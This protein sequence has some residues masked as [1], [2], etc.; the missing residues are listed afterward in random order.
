MDVSVLDQ[1]G[2]FAAGLTAHDFRVLDNGIEQPV[3]FFSPVESPAQIL[4]M[5]E[6]SPAVYLIRKEHISAAYALLDGLAPDDEVALAIYDATPHGV[7]GFTKDKAALLAALSQVQYTIG[8]DELNLYNSISTVLDWVGSSTGKKA[9][10]LLSTGLDSSPSPNWDALIKKLRG[11]DVV[12]F[13]VALGGWLRG[14]PSHKSSAKKKTS[15]GNGKQ[16]PESPPAGNSEIFAKA[17]AALLSLAS[18]TG[19]RAYC[20]ESADDFVPI[21]RQIAYELRNE[22]VLGIQPAQDGQFHSLRVEVIG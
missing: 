11:H 13:P 8:M 5:L 6:T 18:M 14:G 3:A 19:G 1:S 15:R 12:I 22:Y 17:D 20:P 9:L 10:V 21:Y 2:K 4:V 16:E 7:L